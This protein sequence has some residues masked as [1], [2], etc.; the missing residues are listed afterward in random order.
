MCSTALPCTLTVLRVAGSWTLDWQGVSDPSCPVSYPRGQTFAGCLPGH[1][2]M[3]HHL[4]CVLPCCML[5]TCWHAACAH[6]RPSEPRSMLQQVLLDTGLPGQAELPC[7]AGIA[8]LAW[9]SI[10]QDFKGSSIN[11][12]GFRQLIL[13]LCWA[14]GVQGSKGHT[15]MIAGSPQTQG[16]PMKQGVLV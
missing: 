15:F 2:V 1:A 12:Q 3:P 4:A 6:M 14:S 13:V 7:A 11:K 5:H 8:S 16:F 9:P 10:V